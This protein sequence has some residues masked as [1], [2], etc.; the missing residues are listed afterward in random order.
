[1]E[2]LQPRLNLLSH[3]EVYNGYPLSLVVALVLHFAILAALV[4]SGITRPPPNPE[5]VQ[6]SIRA[7]TI[8]ENPQLRNER[9]QQQRIADLSPTGSF[10]RVRHYIAVVSWYMLRRP[11]LGGKQTVS[12]LNA[13]RRLAA[14]E[15]GFARINARSGSL[16]ESH[17]SG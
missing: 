7:F 16:A 1:M 9:I 13:P 15:I 11:F 14:P 3:M 6:P 2:T 17:R 5:I 4:Y 8:D 10:I 12:C